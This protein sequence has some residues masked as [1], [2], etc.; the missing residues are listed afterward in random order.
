MKQYAVFPVFFAVIFLIAGAC[1]PARA[2]TA[3]ALAEKALATPATA[4]ASARE[5]S[6]LTDLL[7]TAAAGI[8]DAGWRDQ[9]LRELAKIMAKQ[10]RIDQAIALLGRIH[11]P[12]TRA[13]AIRG[14]GMAAATLGKTPAEYKELFKTLSFESSKISHPPS[15][16]IAQTYIAMAQALAGDDAG[17][18]ETALM[19]EN[20]A[21]RNKAFAESAEIQAGRLDLPAALASV[22]HIDDPAFRDKALRTVSKI[23]GDKSDYDKALAAAQKIDNNYQRAQALLHILSRQV[24]PDEPAQAEGGTPQNAAAAMPT[25]E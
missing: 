18:T 4:C 6:C 25:I 16:A 13:M 15:Y 8:Q 23:L 9:T 24:T 11:N 1:A 2:N 12:D 22:G 5:I 14:I 21:L 19:M 10:G 7:E 17:A 3:Q 20:P